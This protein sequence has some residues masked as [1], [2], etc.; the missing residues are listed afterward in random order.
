MKSTRFA[1]LPLL[2]LALASAT[3]C[4][5]CNE[6]PAPTDD[7]DGL[8]TNNDPR[9]GEEEEPPAPEP[10]VVRFEGQSPVEVFWG[11]SVELLFS[12][13]TRS[14]AKVTGETVRFSAT[15][16]GSLNVTE[17]QTD[18]NGMARVTFTAGQ[19]DADVLLTATNELAEN[20]E[21]V[22]IQ[23]R[24]NP[25]GSLTVSLNSVT[26]IPVSNAEVLVYRGAAAQTP[27]CSILNNNLANAQTATFL[28]DFN[29]VPGTRT[30]MEQP[31]GEQVTV[32]AVG[33]NAAGD[34]VGTACEDGNSIVGGAV[35][36]VGLTLEQVPTVFTGDYD[37][38]MDVDLGNALPQPYEGYVDTVTGV[39]SDPAGYAVYQ[40]LRQLDDQYDFSFVHWDPNNT[41]TEEL[42]SFEDVSNNPGTFGTWAL[43]QNILEQQL[44]DELGEDYVTVTTVGGD[45][46]QAVTAFEVGT[47]FALTPVEGLEDVYEVDEQWNDIV[48]NWR[49][50]CDE[51]DLG[52]A[53]RPIQLENTDYAPVATAYTAGID[54]APVQNQTERFALVSE[55][56]LFSLRYGAIIMIAMNEV[57]FPSLP[58]GL[59][60]DSLQGVLANI[61]D[62]ADVGAAISNAIGFGGSSMYEGLCNVGLTFAADYIEGQVLELEVGSGNPELGPKEQTGALGEGFFYL[63]DRDHDVATELVRDLEMQ[64]QW[65]DDENGGNEDVTAPILGQGRLSAS[66]CESDAACEQGKACVPVAHYLQVQAVEMTCDT[67]IGMG[68]GEDACTADTQCF[69]GICMNGGSGSG[70]CF[71]ACTDDTA[72]GMGVCTPDALGLDLNPTLQGLG[73]ASV[74]A[75]MEAP[76]AP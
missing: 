74:S 56:H 27:P 7:K 14:G 19:G 34:I 61:I 10:R 29:V 9:D 38:L 3:A 76:V 4:D 48:F 25:F 17:S 20:E 21:A 62:C 46:R 13:K 2:I 11:E 37:V 71:A 23:V 30:F 58:G 5:G 75:C 12:L 60:A 32:Y 45:I 57:I 70:T 54:H 35:T 33:Y 28:G 67:G 1:L 15:T 49:L 31:H 68:L 8:P 40:A 72:C 59:A 51:G 73:T 22:T 63:V 69:S 18:A 64:V 53:R 66:E 50:G 24:V 44:I 47:R 52:C 36:T 55:P 26:R 42:A 43:A 39:L 41:G 65:N 6:A 16:G